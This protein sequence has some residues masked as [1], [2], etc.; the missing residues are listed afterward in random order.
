MK[1][2]KIKR[3][4]VAEY[5]KGEFMADVV[6]VANYILEISREET[7]DGEFELISHMKLQ[8]L[9]YFCQGFSLALS[10]KPLFEGE[11]EAWEHGPVSPKLYHLLKHYGALPI[12]A[13]I[14]P[15]KI[16][17]GEKEKYLINIVYNAYGQYSASR[18]RKITHEVGPWSSTMTNSAISQEAMSKYFLSLIEVDS[19]K[20]IESSD[21]EKRELLNILV[22]AEA[23]SEFKMSQFCIPMG[24]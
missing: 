15:D 19:K 6:D 23:D 12:T 4:F 7:D 22:Q 11:I 8:K 18:L 20:M 21:D 2:N 1:Y 10:G 24:A 16:I 17:L 13:S 14:E 9:V 3:R 5:A